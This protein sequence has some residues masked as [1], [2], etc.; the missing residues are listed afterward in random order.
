MIDAADINIDPYNGLFRHASAP[1]T[2]RAPFT[3]KAGNF[4]IRRMLYWPFRHEQK[5]VH[6]IQL[7]SRQLPKY[8]PRLRVYEPIIDYMKRC[9]VLIWSGREQL[10]TPPTPPPLD[11]QIYM[12]MRAN[13]REY[14]RLMCAR[15]IITALVDGREVAAGAGP[16]LADAHIILLHTIITINT[17]PAVTSIITSS[18]F[19][20][21]L[22]ELNSTRCVA[23]ATYKATG[24]FRTFKRRSPETNWKSGEGSQRPSTAQKRD[25]DRRIKVNRLNPL[26]ALLPTTLLSL[27]I[28]GWSVYMEHSP[29]LS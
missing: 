12:R 17:S 4:R 23:T 2:A 15:L 27:W 18:V 5:G 7:L 16:L 26:T 14:S 29:T 8:G 24:A 10:H 28:G 20:S 21:S 11:G 9:D 25:W 6:I 3:T 1:F 13:N 22:L 19:A